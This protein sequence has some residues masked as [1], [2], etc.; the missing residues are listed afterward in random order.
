[1]H[2]VLLTNGLEHLFVEKGGFLNRADIKLLIAPTTDDLLRIHREEQV[3]LIVAELDTP[4]TKLEAVFSAIRKD[5]LLKYVST[6]VICKDVSADRKR[7]EQCGANAVFSTPVDIPRL[8][9]TARQLL[10]VA[11]RMFYRSALEVEVTGRFSDRQVPFWTE[12]ISANG[13]MIRSEVRLAKGEGLSFS[14][15]L[16]G[17]KTVSGHGEIVWSRQV[18]DSSAYHCGVKFTTIDPAARAMIAEFVNQHT[19]PV[20][21]S[22]IG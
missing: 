10:D 18:Q 11:P 17:G 14:F 5:K 21:P 20:H 1:M 2:K 12:N 9:V 3:H 15:S 8:S 22:R 13:M 19:Q 7:R 4:G 6:I 16:P